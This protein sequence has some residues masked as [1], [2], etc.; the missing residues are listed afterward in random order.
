MLIASTAAESPT[1]TTAPYIKSAGMTCK[2][3]LKTCVMSNLE[4]VK[5]QHDL[6]CEPLYCMV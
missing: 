4:A 5:S 1:I 2:F 6:R 3:P